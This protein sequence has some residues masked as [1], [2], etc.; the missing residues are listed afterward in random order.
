MNNRELVKQFLAGAHRGRSHSM[1]IEERDSRITVLY[2]YHEPIASRFDWDDSIEVEVCDHDYSPTTNKQIG[3]VRTCC[4]F[5]G[6]AYYGVELSK[7]FAVNRQSRSVLRATA[8][9][10]DAPPRVERTG[11]TSR[12]TITGQKLEMGGGWA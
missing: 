5:I 8:G 4:A 12:S 9:L 10:I 2:S 3:L 7:P 11:H 6:S 1:R